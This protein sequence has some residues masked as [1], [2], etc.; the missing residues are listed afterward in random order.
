MRHRRMT[1]TTQMKMKNLG[2]VINKRFVIGINEMIEI[3]RRF[4]IKDSFVPLLLVNETIK[5]C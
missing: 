2:K 4:A 5:Y 3:N 1:L